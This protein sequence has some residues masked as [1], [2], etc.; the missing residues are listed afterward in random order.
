MAACDWKSQRTLKT[1]TANVI[2]SQTIKRQSHNAQLQQQC[3]TRSHS[4]CS[5]RPPSAAAHARIRFRHS[6]TVLHCA[7]DNA[8]I[9]TFPLVHDDALAK[10]FDICN[11]PLVV[12]PLLYDSPYRIVYGVKIRTIGRPQTWWDK[13]RRDFF[14][15]LDRLASSVSW[16]ST[17]LSQWRHHWQRI[18]N[19]YQ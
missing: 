5:N 7:V 8:R 14:Q 10:F 19:V 6:F 9:K 15:Q 17:L 1:V 12:E 4:S 2:S 11:L 16:R 18:Y 3:F 13:I